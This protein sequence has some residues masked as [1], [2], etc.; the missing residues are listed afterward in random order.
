MVPK[1]CR[2][3]DT[4]E[5]SMLIEA[6]VTPG[7]WLNRANGDGITIGLPMNRIV[8]RFGVG[9]DEFRSQHGHRPQLYLQMPFLAAHKL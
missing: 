2:N 8:N 7:F 9:N 3:S 4:R 1:A 6:Y 5:T